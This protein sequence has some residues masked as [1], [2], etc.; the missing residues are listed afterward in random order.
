MH[1]P[2][3]LELLRPVVV[4]LLAAGG[5][6]DDL[7]VVNEDGETVPPLEPVPD[8]PAPHPPDEQDAWHVHWSPCG[9]Q[10]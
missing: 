1:I 8:D 7:T 2:P 10:R 5:E 9:V 4:P 6:D 3:T